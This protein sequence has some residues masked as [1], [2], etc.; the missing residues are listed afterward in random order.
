MAG[1]EAASLLLQAAKPRM[2][3]MAA[4]MANLRIVG[5]SLNRK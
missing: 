2:N 3:E 4:R 1:P 5:S